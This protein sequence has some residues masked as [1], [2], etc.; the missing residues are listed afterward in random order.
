M[1]RETAAAVKPVF[2]ICCLQMKVRGVLSLY[3]VEIEEM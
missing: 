3:R 2:V 1:S